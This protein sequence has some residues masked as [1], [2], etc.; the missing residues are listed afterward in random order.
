MLVGV[1]PTVG[2]I[3]RWG[4]IPITAD[5]DTAG[6]MT[7]T[8]TDADIMLGVLEGAAPDARDATNRCERPPD[9]DYRVFFDA[10]ALGGARI[11]IPR[12]LY[13]DAL[14]VPG[15][16]EPRRSRLSGAGR[17]LMADAIE[18]LESAGATVVDPPY[19]CVPELRGVV[20][21]D[22]SH[23]ETQIRWTEF[24]DVVGRDS[25]PAAPRI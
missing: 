8:V 16:Q 20:G 21:P 19:R 18:G 25:S 14:P 3:S 13:C 15:Q 24:R 22:F 2:P 10:D 9:G 1:K 12:A 11:G 5:Q 23:A 6:P 7:R 4:V 17:A